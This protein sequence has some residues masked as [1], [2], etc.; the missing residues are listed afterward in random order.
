MSKI[1][2][3]P[4]RLIHRTSHPYLRSRRVMLDSDLA[5]LYQVQTFNL[6]KAVKQTWSVSRTFMFRLTGGSR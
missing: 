4:L 3:A 1:Q 5:V 6:N 2:K